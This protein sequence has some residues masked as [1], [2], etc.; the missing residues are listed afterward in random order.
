MLDNHIPRLS[1]VKTWVLQRLAYT[2]GISNIFYL[3]VNQIMMH[4]RTKE[5]IQT[6]MNIRWDTQ[7]IATQDS[8]DQHT[9]NTGLV[10]IRPDAN[11]AKRLLASTIQIQELDA[12]FDQQEAFNMALDQLDLHV[13][14]G[15]TVLLDVIHF[16]NGEQYFE[17]NLSASKGIQPYIVHVNHK[18]KFYDTS[19]F[20]F[21]CN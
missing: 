14:S 11:A 12:R 10:M 2:A 16:P 17:K 18:V 4:T 6:L 15:I 9:V 8:L 20:F 7:L 19:G 21:V 3:E 5:Y 1:H 13:K